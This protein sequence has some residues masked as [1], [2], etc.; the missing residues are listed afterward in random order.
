MGSGLLRHTR[1]LAL[2]CTG[3]HAHARACAGALARSLA[4]TCTRSLAA[5]TRIPATHAC[6]PV[7]TLRTLRMPAMRMTCIRAPAPALRMSHD[8]QRAA[9][10]TSEAH[11]HTPYVMTPIREIAEQ[12]PDLTNLLQK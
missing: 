1:A 9:R 4:H 7:R 8:V 11:S 2:A 10:T 3:A 5:H 6:M 12:Y